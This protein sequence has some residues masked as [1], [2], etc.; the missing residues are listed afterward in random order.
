MVGDVTTW[1]EL[2]TPVAWR[3][4]FGQSGLLDFF[5]GV[6]ALE[7]LRQALQLHTLRFIGNSCADEDENRARVLE[8]NHL[9]SLV[10][11]LADETLI[12]FTVPV[13]YN[14]LVDYGKC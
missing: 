8:G 11:L 12:P 10:R 14:I 5:L 4:P 6:I 9:P 7:P 3:V 1:P 2:T 13:L